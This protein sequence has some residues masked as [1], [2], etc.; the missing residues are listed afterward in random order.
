MVVIVGV[1]CLNRFDIISDIR[2]VWLVVISIGCIIV[3]LIV[4]N[5][6]IIV[7]V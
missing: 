3:V 7:V 5:L 4:L 1:F 2:L 6:V